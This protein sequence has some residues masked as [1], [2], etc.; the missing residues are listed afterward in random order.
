MNIKGLA[1]NK[2]PNFA[3][4]GVTR[5]VNKFLIKYG[6]RVSRN[7]ETKRVQFMST[8][9]VTVLQLYHSHGL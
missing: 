1:A 5:F 9:A 3:A 7:E 2:S 8:I 6:R 4:P